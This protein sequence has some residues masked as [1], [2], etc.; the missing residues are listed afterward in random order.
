MSIICKIIGHVKKRHELL[1][2]SGWSRVWNQAY[3]HHEI[4]FSC[5]RCNKFVVVGLI[6]TNKEGAIDR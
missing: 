2:H 5:T 4:G 1:R 3:D 6:S